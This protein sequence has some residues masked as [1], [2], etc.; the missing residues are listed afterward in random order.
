MKNSALDIQDSGENKKDEYH[1]DWELQKAIQEGI[2]DVKNGRVGS[3]ESVMQ[4]IKEKYNY[5]R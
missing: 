1:N 3:H 4:E 2:E 5:K